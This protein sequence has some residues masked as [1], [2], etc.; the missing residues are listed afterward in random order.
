[1]KFWGSWVFLFGSYVVDFWI[2]GSRLF[3]GSVGE[4]WV[5]DIFYWIGLIWG[6]C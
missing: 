6:G 5:G 4:V 3:L 2:D 1:M